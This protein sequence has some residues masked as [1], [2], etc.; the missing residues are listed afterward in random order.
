MNI[1][2]PVIFGFQFRSGPSYYYLAL[3]TLGLTYIVVNRMIISRTGRA[4]VAIR[5]D[6]EV[7]NMMGIPLR[8]YKLTAFSISAFFAGVA[9]SLYAHYITFISPDSFTLVQTIEI[10]AMM[11]LGG[12][13][14]MPG[15]LLGPAILI[16][17][18]EG[19]RPLYDYRMLIYGGIILGVILVRQEGILGGQTLPLR[20]RHINLIKQ[21]VA[22]NQ[23]TE[24]QGT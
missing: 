15:S 5:D 6:Q 9:G 21:Y 7:A 22:A 14:S 12:M 8:Q 11:V 23:D 2:L 19:L 4:L 10:L 18:S 20:R 13:S 17:A 16:T 3:F 1:P 24:V